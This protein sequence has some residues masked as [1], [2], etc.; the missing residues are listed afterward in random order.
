MASLPTPGELNWNV[1]LDAFTA[2][3]PQRGRDAGERRVDGSG[4]M[5]QS[6]YNAT[7]AQLLPIK[8]G[9]RRPRQIRPWHPLPEG[10]AAGAGERGRRLRASGFEADYPASSG[11]RV[12]ERRA[13]RDTAGWGSAG[14][15]PRPASTVSAP[16]N[17]ACGLYGAGY[18]GPG[19]RNRG[20]GSALSSLAG[21]RLHVGQADR[22]R[23]IGLITEQGA[24][25]TYTKRWLQRIAGALDHGGREQG[26]RRHPARQARRAGDVKFETGIGITCAESDR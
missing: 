21:E 19:L 1:D 7:T 15:K 24:D 14:G 10:G 13:A 6:L 26:Q 23:A 11:S 16:G 22:S 25:D 8:K 9:T 3:R 17:D 18:N 12:G 4:G 5:F 20:S 2:D